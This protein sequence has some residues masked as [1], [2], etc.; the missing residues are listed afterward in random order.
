MRR[1]PLAVLVALFSLTAQAA[2]PFPITTPAPA[3]ALTTTITG[4][5]AAALSGTPTTLA[6]DMEATPNVTRQLSL[7]LA[8][9][10]GNSTTVV[11]KCYESQSGTHWDQIPA[12]DSS[13]ACSP[14]TR[15]YTLS[16]YT[17]DTGVKYIPS[18]WI[19]TKKYAQC[20]A[21][22]SGSGTVTITGARS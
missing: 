15:T 5:T 6:I 20:S 13:G 4:V 3:I 21:Y 11:V 22:D 18:R 1:L 8:V 16:G 12:C 19:I 17:A 2:P 9:T 7:T 14:D 10:P